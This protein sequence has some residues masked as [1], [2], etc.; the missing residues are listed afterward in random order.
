MERSIRVWLVDLEQAT[1]C[2]NHLIVLD[3]IITE[4]ADAVL[5]LWL[6]RWVNQWHFVGILLILLIC[7]SLALNFDIF[8]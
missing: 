2:H 3:V 6:L 8:I 4:V 5:I 1:R 7:Y